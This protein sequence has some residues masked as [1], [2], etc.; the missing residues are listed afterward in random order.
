MEKKVFRFISGGCFAL[1]TLLYLIVAIKNRENYAF[2]S[3]LVPLSFIAVTV[4][5]FTEKHI[6]TLIG[7]AVAATSALYSF[8]SFLT[9]VFIR[10]GL[11]RGQVFGTLFLL[12]MW[13]AAFSFLAL[14]AL[15]AI[16]PRLRKLGMVFAFISGGAYFLYFVLVLIVGSRGNRIMHLFFIAGAVLLGLAINQLSSGKAAAPVDPAVPRT[17]YNAPPQ[18][19][20][21][22]VG[23]A[24]QA[25]EPAYAAPQAP[26][27]AY[28][29]PPQWQAAPVGYAPQVPEPQTNRQSVQSTEN[30]QPAPRAAAIPY[31]FSRIRVRYRCTNGHVFDGEEGMTACKTC[32]A[33]LPSGGFIQLYRMGNPI[34]A[35]VGMGVYIDDVPFGH[36]AT[37]QSIRISVPYGPHKVHVTHTTTRKCNDPVFTVT[38]EMPYAWCK[39]HFSSGGFAITVEQAAPSE[40][41]T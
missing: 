29:A 13:F 12:F 10:I 15:M 40:M 14:A 7:A 19:Q 5:V 26:E 24:P 31:D 34:G 35:A 18:W 41:P 6:V 36:I 33:P 30:W 25:A 21:T 11:L 16:I 17:A 23:Y 37:K 9:N 27:P 28:N 8:L 38:P 22:P 2:W 20:A 1:F 32:G 39:A 3:W 4:G